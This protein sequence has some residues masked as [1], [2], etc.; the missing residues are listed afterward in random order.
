[1]AEDKEIKGEFKSE[2]FDGKQLLIGDFTIKVG[3]YERST[4]DLPADVKKQ[5][6]RAMTVFRITIKNLTGAM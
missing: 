3:S 1:M 6:E 4:V 5:Y 2:A